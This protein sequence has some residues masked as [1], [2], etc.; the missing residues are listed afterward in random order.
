MRSAMEAYAGNTRNLPGLHTLTRVNK[1][2]NMTTSKPEGDDGAP[3]S[4]VSQVESTKAPLAFEARTTGVNTELSTRDEAGSRPPDHKH[5]A[6]APHAATQSR[7]RAAM[8]AR[9]PFTAPAHSARED[10]S[11]FRRRVAA[12]RADCEAARYKARRAFL[13][14]MNRL[15]TVVGDPRHQLFQRWRRVV[16]RAAHESKRTKDI[17]TWDETFMA[18]VSVISMR[19]K[20]PRTRVGAVIVNSHNH[21]VALGYNGFPVG[22]DDDE[23]PWCRTP[24]GAEE[25]APKPTSSDAE[26]LQTKHAY[27]CH[28]EV[29]AVLNKNAE[30]TRGCRL[31]VGLFPCHECAKV[32][33][34]AGI[35]EVVYLD[36]KNLRSPSGRASQR[37]MH[38][39]GVRMRH[40]SGRLSQFVVS[41]A[42]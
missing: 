31:Y 19:S 41:G 3:E 35:R 33:I 16:A 14:R 18:L 32:V 28:A 7:W 12:A 17:L 42:D 10:E 2:S 5:S 13:H 15:E 1:F 22:V 25:G 6:V 9:L 21:V 26:W 24:Y 23:F 38:A 29:N 4:K 36:D 20:D 8:D 40:Y 39:A 34:Q 11:T 27:V 37:M 30:S